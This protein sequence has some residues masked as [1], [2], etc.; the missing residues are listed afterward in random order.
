MGGDCALCWPFR[1]QREPVLCADAGVSR[2]EKKVET[3]ISAK[4]AQMNPPKL[5]LPRGAGKVVRAQ[6]EK[7]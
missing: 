1:L 7:R 2:E 6:T 3:L 5:R 4:E